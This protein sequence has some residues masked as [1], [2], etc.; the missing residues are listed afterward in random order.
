MG[1]PRAGVP[2]G[3]SSGPSK[4]APGPADGAESHPHRNPRRRVYGRGHYRPVAPAHA[5]SPCQ[6][7]APESQGSGRFR[8]R[9]TAK[10]DVSGC[11]ASSDRSRGVGLT[12]APNSNL[13]RPVRRRAAAPAPLI[14]TGGNIAVLMPSGTADSLAHAASQS[15]HSTATVRILNGSRPHQGKIRVSA[16]T[17]LTN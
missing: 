6:R 10:S 9:L 12:R 11:L 5:R 8:R 2:H 13:V 14:F 15:R 17:G 4:A 1:L 7:R 3:H 16:P